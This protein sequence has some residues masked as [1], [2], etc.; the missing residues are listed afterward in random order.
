[1]PLLAT[2]LVL[3]AA[4]THATW[5]LAAKRAS[6]SRHFVWMYSALSMLLYTPVVIW[7]V[8]TTRPAFQAIHWFALTATAVLH[9]A[10]SLMLQAGY[11]ASDLSLVYPL[12]RGSG[13]L[14]SFFLAVVLLNEHITWLSVVGVLL[15]VCGILLVS[16]LLNQKHEAPRDGI[17]FGLGT[18]VFIALYTINDGWAVKVLLISPFIVDYSGNLVRMLVLTPQAWV[19]RARTKV[20]IREFA[21][22][23]IIVSVLGPL[24]YIL[25]LYAMQIAPISHV[26]P[27]R[28]LATLIGTYFG[29]RLLKEKAAPARLAGAVCIV[30]GVVSL[31]FADAS[32]DN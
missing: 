10:Y 2:A 9:I 18:G 16:G 20:E 32:P 13:P 6:A 28:E 1:M 23:V 8:V 21:R 14:L 29:A 24:G 26:A 27:A 17:F 22:P 3:M 19:D 25:V 31:A 12:A 15:V 5:N 11:R 7:I 4:A 30:V